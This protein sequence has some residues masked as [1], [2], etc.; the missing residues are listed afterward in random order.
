[1]NKSDLAKKLVRLAYANPEKRAIILPMIKKLAAA[2][3]SPKGANWKKAENP[4]R[5]N[6]S[7]PATNMAFTVKET[8]GPGAP[9]YI[10]TMLNSEGAMF[11]HIKPA[12][13]F[14]PEEAFKAAASAFKYQTSDSM[15]IDLRTHWS[16]MGSTGKQT[17]TN[18]TGHL[19]GSDTLYSLLDMEIESAGG[20]E[21]NGDDDFPVSVGYTAPAV[22]AM[23][24]AAGVWDD[25]VEKGL[26]AWVKDNLGLFNMEFSALKHLRNDP[27]YITDAL[28]R[29]RGGAPYLYF[30][31]MEGAGVGTWDGDWDHL[32]IDKNTVHVLSKHMERLLHGPF[33]KLKGAISN[34]A[35]VGSE[36]D[37]MDKY[38][39]TSKQAA[40]G[41]DTE[42]FGRWVLSTQSAMSPAEVEAIVNRGLG[43]HTSPPVKMR[44]GPRFQDGDKV[45]V[46]LEKHTGPGKGSYELY[47]QKIGTCVGAD[48]MDLMLSFPGEH[49]PVRFE[50]GMKRQGVGVMKYTPAHAITGSAAMEMYYFAGGKP[51][52][53]AKI[54]VDAYIGRGGKKEKRSANYYT[55]HVVFAS[56][57]EKGWYFRGYPQQRIQV[58]GTGCKG[59]KFLPRTFNPSI[60]EV[61]YIGV[62]GHRPAKWKEE[63]AALDEAAGPSEPSADGSDEAGKTAAVLA[64]LEAIAKR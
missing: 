14:K 62:Q 24:A 54:I 52:E 56:V 6:W 33:S 42:E 25:A 2:G 40:P 18:K 49:A 57:G 44:A 4:T 35:F 28:M 61:Y 50:N 10:L 22:K 15:L 47:D 16:K 32:F 17:S 29:Y 9:L 41:K 30:Q 19:Q 43:I 38:A 8:P 21:Y 55:G 7:D 31:E 23:Q 59:D 53:D 26:L 5:W 46:C 27:K 11:R 3:P 39:T 63:L 37:D 45:M 20:D 58:D 1:M 34:A 64:K 48:G 13:W 36:G 12:Q 60:G 51:T